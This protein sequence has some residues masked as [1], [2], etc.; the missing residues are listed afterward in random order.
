MIREIY[1]YTISILAGLWLNNKINKYNEKLRRN[2]K[3][4]R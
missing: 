2:N 4:D 1:M 3:D